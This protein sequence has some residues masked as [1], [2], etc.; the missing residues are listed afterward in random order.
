[1]QR[2]AR[3]GITLFN[4]AVLLKGINATVEAQHD[5]CVRLFDSGVIPY[6][7]H[8]LDKVQGAAHFDVAE[9]QARS[10]MEELRAH[11]PGYMLPRLVRE[12][13]GAPGKT[14]L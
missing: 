14:D 7:L 6:Y 2:L 3:A 4:Q 12:I 5:L 1:L 9:H 10:L 13:P 8:T 11:L